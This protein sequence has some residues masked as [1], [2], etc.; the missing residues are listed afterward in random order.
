M[1]S[2][3]QA[4]RAVILRLLPIGLVAGLGMIG[5][6]YF[7][8]P[9]LR[10]VDTLAD[11]MA[12]ALRCAGVAALT[13]FAGIQ[14][15]ASQRGNSAAIDP[16]A[17]AGREPRVMQIHARYTQNTLEQLVLFVIVLGALSTYLDAGS[18]HLLPILTAVFI[19][20]RIAF[21]VG[22]LRDP[23][24]RSPGMAI[25]FVINGLSLIY[26]AY[27]TLRLLVGV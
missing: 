15:V 21:W 7:L 11:R 22:Y 20:G 3:L 19:L 14:A 1:N 4:K 2:E 18:M 17:G 8:V 5:L 10:G 6:L 26:I 12:V 27:R 16:I 13:L 23:L 25:A 9:P 24:F